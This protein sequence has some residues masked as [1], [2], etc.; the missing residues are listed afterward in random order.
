MNLD[1]FKA[2]DVRGVYPAELDETVFREIGRAFVTFLKAKSIGVGRD[3]RVSSPSL[4]AAFIEGA[5]AQG[6]NVVEYGM[7]ATDMIYYGVATD[8]LDGGAQITASH[9]PKQYNGCKMVRAEA[10][11]LSGEEGIKEMKEMILAGIERYR[12]S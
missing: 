4:A 10:F 5:L 6:C 8:N 3:M 12:T 2:Y 1:I 7:I 11:P 9:N